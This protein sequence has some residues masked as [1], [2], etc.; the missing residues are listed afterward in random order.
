MNKKQKVQ[1]SC[2]QCGICCEKGGAALHSEDIDLLLGGKIPKRD[3]ITIRKGEYAWNPVNDTLEATRTEVIKLRGRDSSWICCYLH[4]SAKNCTIYDTRPVSCRT[5]K[6]WKPEASLDIA[7]RDLLSRDS[8]L[9]MQGDTEMRTLVQEFERDFEL[10]DFSALEIDLQVQ[11]DNLMA[12]LEE[13]VNRD[14]AFRTLQVQRSKAMAVEELFFFGR[15]LFQLLQLFGVVVFQS[16]NRLC[17]EKRKRK[18]GT[19]Y[20]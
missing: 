19:G 10:P 1:T 14:L 20:N 9:R 6:C 5:L 15:P 7:G 3:L 4:P 13:A 12:D 18:N 11:P 2:R 8:I 17:L 16:G